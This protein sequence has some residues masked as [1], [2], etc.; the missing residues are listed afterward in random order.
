MFFRLLRYL[1]RQSKYRPL[2]RQRTMA[3]YNPDDVE[4]DPELLMM[5]NLARDPYRAAELLNGER[6]SW[7]LIRRIRPRSK[8]RWER[9]VR[10]L[11]TLEGSQ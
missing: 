7:P 3:R 8:H 9:F 2:P 5:A 10:W 1:N 6:T 4:R 11:Q